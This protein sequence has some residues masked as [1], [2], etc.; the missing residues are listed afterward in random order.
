MKS[1][2]RG[3]IFNVDA[4]SLPAV[5]NTHTGIIP[6]LKITCTRTKFAYDGSENQLEL[7]A[8]K[9]ESTGQVINCVPMEN[10]LEA[11]ESTLLFTYLS[12]EFKVKLSDIEIAY[13]FRK[14]ENQ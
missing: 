2:I 3:Y 1:V 13:A 10:E 5:T 6:M 4:K 12:Q 14:W 11:K 8:F 7:L 9:N